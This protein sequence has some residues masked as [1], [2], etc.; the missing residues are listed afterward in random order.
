MRIKIENNEAVSPVVGVMLMLVVTIIIAAVV[1]SFAG[2]LASEQKKAPTI[3]VDVRLYA[4][5]DWSDQGNMNKNPEIWFEHIGGESVPTSE[6]MII[7]YYVVPSTGEVFKHTVDGSL[8]PTNDVNNDNPGNI[9]N[10]WLNDMSK[11]SMGTWGTKFGQFVWSSG[12]VMEARGYTQMESVLGIDLDP[13]EGGDQY[14]FGKGSVVEVKI[15]HKPSGQ[16]IYQNKV[17]AI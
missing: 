10:P 6:L 9:G 16:Y 14:E 17:I 2:G 4:N 13:D 15:L 5:Y 1:S 7:T 12:D 11:G 8:D 3:T